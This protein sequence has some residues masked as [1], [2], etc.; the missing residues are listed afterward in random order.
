MLLCF[1]VGVFLMIRL[2]PR[3]TRTDTLFPYTT[4]V[5]SCASNVTFLEFRKR[6]DGRPR[7]TSLKVR[8]PAVT[9]SFGSPS[10]RPRE[11]PCRSGA[12]PLLQEGGAQGQALRVDRMAQAR[13]QAVSSEERRVGKECVSTCRCRESPDHYKKNISDI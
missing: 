12:Q 7:R 9:P 1:T 10:R 11:G 5:R 3:S 6:A 13:P 8:R 2:P 4:L